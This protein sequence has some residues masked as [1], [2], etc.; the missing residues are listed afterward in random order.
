MNRQRLDELAPLKPFRLGRHDRHQPGVES[1]RFRNVAECQSAER[2]SGERTREHLRL[3]DTLG[4]LDHQLVSIGRT[5]VI[6]DLPG[7][8]P[9][10]VG[11]DQLNL[12]LLY[13]GTQSQRLVERFPRA[14]EAPH[15]DEKRAEV[16]RGECPEIDEPRRSGE[17]DGGFET[18]PRLDP[19]ARG[20]LEQPDV[21]QNPHSAEHVT[22]RNDEIERAGEELARARGSGGE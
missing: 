18:P 15:A 17:L 22:H 2:P 7:E 20:R 13:F 6:L 9:Q 11:A 8:V 19:P 21:V 4:Q 16:Q 10:V 12:G 3:T 5:L 14:L 1:N